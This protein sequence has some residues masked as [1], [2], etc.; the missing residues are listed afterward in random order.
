MW[1]IDMDYSHKL[2]GKKAQNTMQIH[3]VTQH[4][5]LFASLQVQGKY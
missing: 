2:R 5:V 4:D 3:P 1:K